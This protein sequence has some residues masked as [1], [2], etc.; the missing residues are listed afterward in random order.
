MLGADGHKK[1]MMKGITEIPG[2][3]GKMNWKRG[4]KPE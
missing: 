2:L 1:R 4:E 3:G